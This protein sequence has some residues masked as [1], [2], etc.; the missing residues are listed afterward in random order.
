MMLLEEVDMVIEAENNKRELQLNSLQLNLLQNS[1]KEA[2]IDLPFESTQKFDEWL[3]RMIV[4]KSVDHEKTDDHQETVGFLKGMTACHIKNRNKRV[5]G[6]YDTQVKK[7]QST[8]LSEACG[9]LSDERKMWIEMLMIIPGVS[10]EKALSIER[11]Y[12]NLKSLMELYE[13]CANDTARE[14][15]LADLLVHSKA[16]D[17]LTKLGKALSKKIYQ[18]FWSNDFNASI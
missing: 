1:Q 6:V 13:S 8:H 18:V 16:Q 2:S 4:Q 15:I 17:K 12:K 5:Y 3:I 14:N 10:E 7:A 9:A 11:Q